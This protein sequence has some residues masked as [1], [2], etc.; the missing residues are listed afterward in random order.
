MLSG[1]LIG[2]GAA[3]AALGTLMNLFFGP[4][5]VADIALLVLLVAVAAS[6]FLASSLPDIPHLR[7]I[8]LVV[9]LIGF[10]VALDRIGF[11]TAGAGAL[12]LLLGTAAASMGAIIVELGRDQPMGGQQA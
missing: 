6:V 7:L 11:G 4:L 2:I 1:W 5:N 10:G 12:L 9:V 3:L 8:T